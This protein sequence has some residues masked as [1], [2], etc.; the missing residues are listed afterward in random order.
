MF[1]LT[2]H[3]IFCIK[4]DFSDSHIISNIILTL[5]LWRQK[6]TS[7]NPEAATKGVLLKKVFLEI[8]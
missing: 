7:E 1:L 8:S 4:I 6:E 5:F 2:F 3:L